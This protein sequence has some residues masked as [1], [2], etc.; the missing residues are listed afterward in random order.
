MAAILYQVAQVGVLI[1]TGGAVGLGTYYALQ[2]G[3]YGLGLALN[4][5]LLGVSRE[6]E[7]EAD[8]LG[9]QYAWKSGYDPAGFI[10]FF[11]R[12]AHKEGYV[13]G[14]SWF[15]THPPFSDRM[16]A[17]QR[18]IQFLPPL[19]S[20]IVQ[21]PTFQSVQAELERCALEAKASDESAD[22]RP[23]LFPKRAEEC[24]P[25]QLI[26][27]NPEDPIESLCAIVAGAPSSR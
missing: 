17:T 13:R 23:T 16:I 24:E 27:Y 3:F 7:R 22:C 4:L 26:E 5:E 25:P 10:R 2:Y 18:E 14:A 20:Y 1:A 21:T 8:Q 11:D 15:R 6:Y 9:V 12:M 19:E